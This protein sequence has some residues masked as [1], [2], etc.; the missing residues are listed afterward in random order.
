M[1]RFFTWPSSDVVAIVEPNIRDSEKSNRTFLSRRRSGGFNNRR[2]PLVRALPRRS[3]VHHLR[4]SMTVPHGG[5]G[6]HELQQVAAQSN[7]PLTVRP[8]ASVIVASMA[9]PSSHVNVAFS[10]PNPAVES[11]L[12]TVPAMKPQF[13]EMGLYGR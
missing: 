1:F 13:P 12:S 7:V 11:D 9:Y 2:D 6:T 8:S 4:V 3:A 10:F 5:L